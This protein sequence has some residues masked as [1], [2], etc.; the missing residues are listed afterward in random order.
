MLKTLFVVTLATF[1]LPSVVH[2]EN[3]Y[4]NGCD[5]SDIY[6]C[7][8]LVT[9]YFNGF[10]GFPE[11]KARALH[12]FET[13]KRGAWEGC[14]AG[15]LPL[16]IIE[17]NLVLRPLVDLP[18]KDNDI[19]SALKHFEAVTTAGCETGSSAACALRAGF[20]AD[21]GVRFFL[22]K[23]AQ[24]DGQPIGELTAKWQQDQNVFQVKMSIAA[25]ADRTVRLVEGRVESV[26][27]QS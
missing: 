4:K 12:L 14:E 21:R 8:R 15:R 23:Q 3:A 11:D 17:V 22:L 25:Q 13:A 16:C 1:L 19:T 2:A 26:S 7:S 6:E 20:Y 5:G 18:I 24:K 27:F 9:N 10:G